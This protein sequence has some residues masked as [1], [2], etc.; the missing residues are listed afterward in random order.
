MLDSLPAVPAVPGSDVPQSG[1]RT[2]DTTPCCPLHIPFPSHSHDQLTR[3]WEEP[4]VAE[5]DQARP[6]LGI[7][8]LYGN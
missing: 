6:S 1:I 7:S 2:M 3:L 8:L 5:E 4:E